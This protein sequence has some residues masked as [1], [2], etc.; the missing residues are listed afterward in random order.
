MEVSSFSVFSIRRFDFYYSP[1]KK[2]NNSRNSINKL[3]FKTACRDEMHNVVRSGS[4]GGINSRGLMQA[5]HNLTPTMQIS[6]RNFN[7][8]RV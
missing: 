6:I 4:N 8:N 7:L 5:T 2:L 1:N 3:Q